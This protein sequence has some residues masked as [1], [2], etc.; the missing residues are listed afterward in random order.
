M[1]KTARPTSRN[2]T[3]LPEG[4]LLVECIIC[5]WY[6][7]QAFNGDCRDDSNSFETP[8]HDEWE[9]ECFDVNDPSKIT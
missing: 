3:S 1:T 6:H 5:G 2:G 7:P 4:Q 8:D 9:T